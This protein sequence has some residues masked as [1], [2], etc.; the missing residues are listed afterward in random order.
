MESACEDASNCRVMGS[1]STGAHQPPPAMTDARGHFALT[2]LPRGRYQVVAEAQAGKLRGRAADVTTD[3]QISIQ[4]TTVGA[5]RG[6][7]RG[8]RGPA[9]L[10]SV[11][12]QGPSGDER[13]FT[14]GAFVFPKLDPGDYSIDVTASEGTGKA[15][16][17]VS[18][19]EEASIDITLVANGTVTGRVVDKAG[20]P[21]SGMGVALIP[22]QPPGQLS[23][24][25]REPPPNSGPDGRFQVV[26]P[27]GMR[28][29]VI[30]GRKPTAKR[31][32]SVASDRTID[33]GDVTI[34]PASADEDQSAAKQ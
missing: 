9:D 7:V 10:F 4:L 31:G 22:D 1:V 33:V 11:N 25:L 16:A 26:G 34:D 32:V 5:L 28:T 18:P 24:M 20:K 13:S 29:L 12:V 15:T 17:R 27:P 6:I 23:I 30:M 2:S 19:G 14:D 8:P 3:A 21:L